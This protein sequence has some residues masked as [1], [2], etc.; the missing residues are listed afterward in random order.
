[1][2]QELLV[3]GIEKILNGDVVKPIKHVDFEKKYVVT[4]EDHSKTGTTC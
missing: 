4:M 2:V 1:M 3:D